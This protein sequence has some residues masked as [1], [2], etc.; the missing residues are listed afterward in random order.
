[1]QKALQ[2]LAASMAS[3]IVCQTGVYPLDTIRTRM[4][5]TPGL[6]TGVIDGWKKITAAEG[7]DACA[8]LGRSPQCVWWQ[9]REGCSRGWPLPTRSRCRTMGP[10]SS[11]T[12]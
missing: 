12:T 5:T 2:T 11:R 7:A 3:G 4:T 10:S 9:G 8:A 1:M 6:Y